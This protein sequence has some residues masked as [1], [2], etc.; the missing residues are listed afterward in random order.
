MSSINAPT[1]ADQ[2][3][4]EHDVSEKKFRLIGFIILLVSFGGFG[5]WAAFA[6][7]DSASL[8]P[9]QVEVKGNRKT[10]QHLEGGIVKDI[11]VS[12][13]D[14]VE[15]GERLIVMDSTQFAA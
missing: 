9:G 3:A 1:A 13:G 10:V 12:D 4:S 6:P 5:A 2:E 11:L 7:L 15:E 8:A 14:Y